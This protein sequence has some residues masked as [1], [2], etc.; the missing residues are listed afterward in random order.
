MTERVEIPGLL[1]PGQDGGGSTPPPRTLLPF[2]KK[3]GMKGP[4]EVNIYQEG[5]LLVRA[6]YTR[7]EAPLQNASSL[8]LTHI[9]CPGTCPVWRM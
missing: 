3:N 8:A 9:F 1:L 6:I 2:F 4:R 5:R 7:K